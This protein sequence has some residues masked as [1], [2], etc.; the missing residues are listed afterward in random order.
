MEVKEVRAGKII[1]LVGSVS[2]TMSK[3]TVAKV[4]NEELFECKSLF[5]HGSNLSATGYLFDH[6][7]FSLLDYNII[8]NEYN[9]HKAFFT[10]QAAKRYL[11]SIGGSARTGDRNVHT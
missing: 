3:F 10:P 1:W 2:K 11:I 4:Q 8:K 9:H 5:A 6:D 7:E